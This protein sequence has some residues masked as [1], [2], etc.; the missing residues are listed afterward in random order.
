MTHTVT[1][2]IP[3][4]R[5]FDALFAGYAVTLVLNEREYG[6]F[7]RG[8]KDL[9]ANLHFFR[10]PHS[11]NPLIQVGDFCEAASCDIILG[12][13]HNNAVIFNN[14]LGQFPTERQQLWDA[15]HDFFTNMTRG[16]IVIGSNVVVSTG[17]IILSGVTIGD[18]AVIGA[19]A[20][21]SHDVPPYAIVAGNPAKVIRYRFPEKEIEALLELRWWDWDLRFLLEHVPDLNTASAA[22]VLK[23]IGGK[24]QIRYADKT[25]RLRFN[26]R[27]ERYHTAKGS[28]GLLGV[29]LGERFIPAAELPKEFLQ[30]TKQA[31]LPEDAEITLVDDIFTHFGIN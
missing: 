15:G 6:R 23:R 5:R 10:S 27:G 30:Y 8:S 14:C 9:M 12:G 28:F 22:E 4:A 26:F 31:A 29:E 16:P 21:V 1:A 18:G 20:V 11:V 24:E 3:L 2:R 25:R 19:G 17:A 13:D 7:G